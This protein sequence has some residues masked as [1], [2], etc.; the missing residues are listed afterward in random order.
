VGSAGY[1]VSVLLHLICVIVGYGALGID[2]LSGTQSQRF[3]GGEAYAVA[4][5]RYTTTVKVATRF[6]YGVPVFGLLAVALSQG[7]ISMGEAWISAALG[8][9]LVSVGVLHGMV[10]PARR[11]MLVL[12]GELAGRPDD[13][14]SRLTTRLSTAGQKAA[15]G[16]SLISLL[17]VAALVLMIWKPGR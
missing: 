6:L 13:A 8:V 3:Q 9:W 17:T 10:I 14:M 2:W 1:N 16:Q 15:L 5:A 4:Q 12:L 11:Q 7:D